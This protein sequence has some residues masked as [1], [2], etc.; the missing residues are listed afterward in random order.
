MNSAFLD[1]VMSGNHLPTCRYLPP[2][3]P[4][5][6]PT[7]TCFR[8]YTHEHTTSTVAVHNRHRVRIHPLPSS[9]PPFLSI[10]LFACFTQREPKQMGIIHPSFLSIGP[11]LLAPTQRSA[12]L[13]HTSH[14]QTPGPRSPPANA[15]GASIKGLKA[16]GSHGYCPSSKDPYVSPAPP[17]C[18]YSPNS[19]GRKHSNAQHIC[20]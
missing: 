19:L 11:Q 9:L 14:P 7:H 20:W 16:R 5:S 10:R 17:N 2:P 18:S 3:I 8:T 13:N 6:S 12:S 15:Q 4:P 1:K